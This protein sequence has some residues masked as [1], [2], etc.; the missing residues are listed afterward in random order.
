MATIDLRRRRIDA[1]IVY[2]GPGLSGKTTNLQNIHARLPEGSRGEMRSIATEGERTLFFDFVPIEPVSLGGWDIRFHL[3][4]VPGQDDYVRTRRALLAGADG[5]VF[6]A[7]AA[8]VRRAANIASRD[9]LLDHLRHYGKSLDTMALVVQVNKVDL[10][11]IV[12]PLELGK[13]LALGEAPVIEAIALQGNG[14]SETLAT[15]TRAVA[16]AL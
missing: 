16:R 14:V 15:I 7:D 12:D 1:R 11:E 13:L 3:Y 6:V 2:Y 8:P 5:I 10:P 9:E 4:S